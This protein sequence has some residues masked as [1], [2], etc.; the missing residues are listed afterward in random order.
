[1]PLGK[2]TSGHVEQLAERMLEPGLKPK[3]VRN[4]LAFLH[5]I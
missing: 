5:S 4:V 2:V 1:M 3:T